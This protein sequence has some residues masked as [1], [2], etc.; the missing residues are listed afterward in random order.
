MF[1]FLYFQKEQRCEFNR[2]LLS[3]CRHQVASSPKHL[4]HLANHDDT[5]NSLNNVMNFPFFTLLMSSTALSLEG[6]E[7]RIHET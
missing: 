6:H 7:C 2:K 5:N 4:I 3:M 1:R